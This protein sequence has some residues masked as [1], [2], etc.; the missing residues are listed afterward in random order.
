MTFRINENET[1]IFDGAM[2]TMLQKRGLKRGEIPELLNLTA[3]EIIRSVHDE[4]F[5]AGC[6][7][8]SAN[9][10]GANRYKAEM[11]GRPLADLV[12]S[13][14]EIA[15]KAASCRKGKY[16]ALDIGPCGRVLQPTG[17]LP[18]EEAVEVFSEIVRA[19]NKAG[20]DLILLETFTDLYE[21]KA[22]LLAAKENS[23]L[24]VLATM[25]FEENGTSFFGA[26][27]E[28]MVLTLQALGADALGVNCSLGPKQLVPIVE[29][30]L[31]ASSIPVMVQPNAGLP[32]FENGEARYD[33]TPE[34]FADHIKKFTEDGAVIVGGCCGTD[35]GY[36]RLVKERL[37]GVASLRKRPPLR[38][39]V[40]SPSRSV[41]F[42]DDTLIIGERLNPTG[43]K[44][45]QAALR[46]KDMD[47]V[48]KE[49]ICQ[50]EQ[51]A[52]ILDVNMGLPDI[53]EPE[54]LKKAVIEIQSVVDLPLQLDS[55][56]PNALEKAARVYNGKPL[57]NSVNGKKE[58]LEK[59]LPI[60]KKYG[61]AVLGLTLDDDGIPSSAEG[62]LRI[63]RNIMEEAQKIGIPKEDVLIDCL[64]MTVSAQQEQAAETLKAVRMVREELGLK[65]VLGVSNVSFGLPS[66][67][68]INRTMLTMALMQG[69]DAPIMNPGDKGMRESIAA[70]RVLM[71]KDPQ[72]SGFIAEYSGTDEN[73]PK[74]EIVAGVSFGLPQAIK[75]GLKK[76][77]EKATEALLSRMGPLKIIEN[78]IIPSLDSVG[79]EYESQTIFLPQLM[80]SAEA[81]K[82]SFELLRGIIAKEGA[83]GSEERAK[84]VIATVQGDIHDIGKNIVKVIMENYNFR[85]IDLGKDVPPQRVVEAVKENGAEIVGLSAL[86]TTTVSSMKATIDLLRKECPLVKVIV[87]G[88]VLTDSL[89]EYVGADHYAKDAMEAV[90]ILGPK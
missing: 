44:A 41:F 66:R 37:E 46:A 8:V 13:A 54:M 70:F 79:K 82:A 76:E 3:P 25:S 36:I 14:V 74:T 57:I 20:A 21:L 64:V 55:S 49:A 24:P 4:Y 32:L 1:I 45:L 27:V 89:A 33:V 40:C 58:S 61:A 23:D 12:S 29:R 39:G 31:R 59:I 19:G 18:F 2:G 81:A 42:G 84:I 11:A 50:Q 28:S 86:M 10:F 47:H 22:A 9:T 38:T 6:D 65:T 17:D 16:A 87:G 15:K 90:R 48:L 56:D 83:P 53:D 71:G 68:I 52:H 35:P 63:A 62:R 88:A 72:A 51:G 7:V 43:K 73:Q 5:D 75:R 67:P 85:M 30:L 80:K 78:E 26:T 77:A 60:V 69:L 34:E